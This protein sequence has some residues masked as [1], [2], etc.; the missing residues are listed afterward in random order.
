M[1]RQMSRNEDNDD[2]RSATEATDR[3]GAG[4]LIL[5][6]QNKNDADQQQCSEPRR[7]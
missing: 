3:K 1:L 5:H 4:D 6:Y 2:N 7:D